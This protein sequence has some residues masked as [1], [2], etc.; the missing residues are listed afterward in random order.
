MDRKAGESNDIRTDFLATESPRALFVANILLAIA[1][2]TAFVLFFPRGNMALYVFLVLGEVF[3]IWQVATFIYTI[4]DTRY[5]ASHTNRRT[6][7]VDVFVTTAGEP[8]SIIEQTVHA[9]TR[10]DYAGPITTYILNDGYVAKKD[11]WRDAEMLAQRAHTPERPVRCITRTVPG[12]AKAGN[13]NNAL[14]LSGS[15]LIAIFD[16]D[17]VPHPDFLSVTV[18][19]FEDA[20]VGFVQTPQFYKNY[21]EN[22]LTRSSWEQQELF[23]GAICRGKNRL[24]AT[25]LCGTN[26]LISRAAL[27]EVGGLCTESIAEDFVT[28]L[29]MHQKGYRSVYVP[30]VLAEGLATEDL[31][32]YSRQQFRWARGALDVIFRYNPLFLPGLTFAQRVQYLASASFYLSGV[33]VLIDMMLPIIFL[34]TGLVPLRAPGMLLAAVFLP[35]LL[36][37]L[38]VIQRASNNTFTFPS[39]GLSMSAFHIHVRALI[40]AITRQRS[41][42]DISSKVPLSGNLIS[43]AIPHLLYIALGSIGIGV[44][45]MREGLSSSLMNN[46]AW[47][48]LNAVVFV[49]FIHAALPERHARTQEAPAPKR[50]RLSDIIPAIVYGRARQ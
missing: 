41:A 24:N 43:L 30:K 16:A 1:Y 12:G 18:P 31:L 44:A 14:A 10:M 48:V 8:V 35:Y 21:A 22:Y 23:Y 2:F 27:V 36:V 7:A 4:W 13:V 26:M 25:P 29:F 34:Y 19:Y 37:T 38:Q 39:I 5:E 32:T 47:M 20:T 15:P 9:I 40:A 49:P 28:G 3:H 33:V 17:H 6:P 11:N 45:L 42:F 50:S 46:V